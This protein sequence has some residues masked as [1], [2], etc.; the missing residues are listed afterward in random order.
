[1]KWLYTEVL[2]SVREWFK[3]QGGCVEVR[4]F[5]IVVRLDFEMS[6]C[7]LG[8]VKVGFICLDFLIC[9]S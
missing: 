1:M 5:S 9:L 2:Q 3:A 4:A 7:T 8:Y 6:N